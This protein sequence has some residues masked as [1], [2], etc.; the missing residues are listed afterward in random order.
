MPNVVKVNQL[1]TDT[2]QWPQ[3]TVSATSSLTERGFSAVLLDKYRRS[4][5]LVSMGNGA[6]ARRGDRVSWTGGVYALQKQLQLP[7]H[8]GGKAALQLHGH[9]HYVPARRWT[10]TLYGP[11]GMRLPTW[12]LR[13]KW[14][15]TVQHVMTNLFGKSAN[16][17]LEEKSMGA[18]GVTF[19]A[20][21][22]AMMELL[23]LVPHQQSFEEAAQLMEQL[24]TLRPD[25]VTDLLRACN[26]I[27]VKRL[28]LFLADHCNHP[29]LS[30]VDRKKFDLGRGKRQVVKGGELDPKYEIT[31]PKGFVARLEE[32][33]RP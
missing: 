1:M 27:K 8:V 29:W 11:P 17:A 16:V 21:E 33:A 5:W 15:V 28:F 32:N 24:G 13:H 3:G 30:K 18:Y 4:G 19:S 31:V 26:S 7:V 14:E 10:A 6:V 9:V 22:R 23:H 2:E 12:F 20:R 25:V